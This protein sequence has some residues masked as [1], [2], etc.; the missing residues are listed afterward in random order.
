M[1]KLFSVLLLSALFCSGSFAKDRLPA[2]LSGL[3]LSPIKTEYLTHEG[4]VAVSF[5]VTI[6]ANYFE[7]R[8]TFVLMPTIRLVDGEIIELPTKGVQGGSVIETHYP[9]VD[10]KNEQVISYSAKVPIQSALLHADFIIDVFLYNCLSKEERVDRLYEGPLNL[11]VFPIAPVMAPADVMVGDAQAEARP[12]GRIFYK[13]NSYTVTREGTNNPS[14]Q[15]MNDMLKF[16]MKDDQFAITEITVMGNASPEGTDRI[17]KPLATN[18]AKSATTWMK[19]NLKTIG[20]SKSLSDNQY[21][22]VDSPDFWDEF[23][24]AMTASDHPRKGEIVSQFLGYKSDPVEAEKKVRELIKN[25]KTVSDILF[26]DLRYSVIR[27]NFNRAAMDQAQLANAAM[28][29][30]AILSAKELTRVAEAEPTLE[31]KAAMY[32]AAIDLYPTTWELYANLGNVYLKMK[33]YGAARNIFNDALKL[34]PRNN[35]V[36][37][38]LAYTYLATGDFDQASKSLEG[39]TGSEADYYRGII[40]LAKGQSEQAI[41]LLK[42]NPDA[43]L[44]IAQLN[45][46]KTKDAYDTLQKLDQE[47]VYTA[48]YTGVALR[49]LNRNNEAENY[50][51]KARQLN[52]NGEINDRLNVDYVLVK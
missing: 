4:K 35:K 50:F 23:F 19:Q 45:V 3:T 8:V 44:A 41:P 33:D 2:D 52:N 47:N 14:I 39:V 40:L 1:K 15:R 5:N 31:R 20:Y 6:P 10:W 46:R 22:I 36:K 24:T 25:D 16:L 32:K 27:V 28:L 43:N 48:F 12:E 30:P 42:N 9:V 7:R 37:A 17:N 11:A 13:V 51:A 38:Q 21:K 26:P 29:Y 18:R 34:D 49:R